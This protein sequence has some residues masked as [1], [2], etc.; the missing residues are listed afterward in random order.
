MIR[1]ATLVSVVLLAL[2]LLI[3]IGLAPANADTLSPLAA[4]SEATPPPTPG[5]NEA[6]IQ[7][8]SGSVTYLPWNKE[9]TFDQVTKIC[10]G[11]DTR[12]QFDTTARSIAVQPGTCQSFPSTSGKVDVNP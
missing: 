11:D 9:H 1:L 5:N 2:A 6:S 4:Q 8:T 7:P 10:T 12:A 3:S